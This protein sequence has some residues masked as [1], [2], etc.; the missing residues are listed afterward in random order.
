MIKIGR[1]GPRKEPCRSPGGR[2][3][4][5]S[6]PGPCKALPAQDPASEDRNATA[7]PRVRSRWRA[8]EQDRVRVDELSLKSN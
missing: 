5:L 6:L 3:T 4:G 2:A 8:C 7:N 1:G